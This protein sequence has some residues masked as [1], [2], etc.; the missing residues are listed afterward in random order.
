MLLQSVCLALVGSMTWPKYFILDNQPQKEQSSK[1]ERS[2]DAVK[3]KD[4]VSNIEKS[5]SEWGTEGNSLNGSPQ[6]GKVEQLSYM[7]A[8]SNVTILSLRT[9]SRLVGSRKPQPF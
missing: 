2:A 4:D 1:D 7:K 6:V 3:T 8:I 9:V 5:Q